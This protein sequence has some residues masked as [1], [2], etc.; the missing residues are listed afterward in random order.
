MQF[1]VRCVQ[2]PTQKPPSTQN[3]H[4]REDANKFPD[5]KIGL[6]VVL[7]QYSLE[8]VISPGNFLE[9][10]W[11]LLVTTRWQIS[12]HQG[13]TV[14]VCIIVSRGG[15]VKWGERSGR[16]VRRLPHSFTPKEEDIQ[17]V[18]S[19]KNFRPLN[20]VKFGHN[21]KTKTAWGCRFD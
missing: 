15:G 18:L 19:F 17:L 13:C 8:H 11:P 5:F 12:A 6:I 21:I 1:Y 3:G 14:K 7:L 4:N 10:H 20:K 2:M 9:Y 16:G